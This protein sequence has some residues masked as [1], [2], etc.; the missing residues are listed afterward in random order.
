MSHFSSGDWLE[1]AREVVFP[2]Q[3]A[4]MQRHLDDGCHRCLGMTEKWRAVLEV[5]RRET[6]YCPPESAV[7]VVKSAYLPP[8]RL[9]PA[10][11]AT[12]TAR[13]VFDSFFQPAP[14]GLR[15]AMSSSRQIVY[16]ADP[17]VIDLILDSDPKRKRVCLL[18]QVLNS[19]QLDKNAEKIEVALL[20]E[21]RVVGQTSAN[22]SGEF[23]FEFSDEKDLRLL[24]N[25]RA[26]SPIEIAL[27]GV[28]VER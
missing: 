2:E 5:T 13:L 19:K 6:A 18:G 8:Q 27:P 20:S 26:H 25:I 1:F 17:F 3:R 15:N 12:S 21:E 23:L 7:R 9:S 16:E 4:V 10:T 24:I 22:R 14:A 28:E 11:Q